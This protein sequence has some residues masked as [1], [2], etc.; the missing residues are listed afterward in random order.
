MHQ[1]APG[2]QLPSQRRFIA[3]KSHLSMILFQ[4]WNLGL[5]FRWSLTLLERRLTRRRSWRSLVNFLCCWSALRKLRSRLRA[6]TRLLLLRLLRT[7]NSLALE[8]NLRRSSGASNE[9]TV[10]STINCSFW[11]LW[12]NGELTFERCGLRSMRLTIRCRI[13]CLGR[14]LG[15]F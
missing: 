6:L 3:M 9:I 12:G 4:G 7:S 14:F 5:R 10:C 8:C 13:A 15:L 1:C 2:N 11:C